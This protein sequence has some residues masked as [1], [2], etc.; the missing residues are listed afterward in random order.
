MERGGGF[1]EVV[2]AGRGG[3]RGLQEVVSEEWRTWEVD[4]ANSVRAYP[5]DLYHHFVVSNVLTH[6]V[7][8]A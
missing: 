6:Q 4:D 7:L 1:V 8:C 3:R 5:G 2:G